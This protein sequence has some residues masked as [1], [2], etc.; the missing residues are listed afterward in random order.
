MIEL[1]VDGQELC[2][3]VLKD[4]VL[5]NPKMERLSRAQDPK[6][7]SQKVD[8]SRYKQLSR[9]MIRR[10]LADFSEE[11]HEGLQADLKKH[12][13]AE[14]MR[15]LKP[16][17]AISNSKKTRKMVKS[18][19]LKMVFCEMMCMSPQMS[20]QVS[21]DM[22][23]CVYMSIDVYAVSAAAAAAGAAAAATAAA[24]AAAAASAAAAAAAAA[25]LY[26]QC[27]TV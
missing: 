10:A 14:L 21:I 16:M 9:M 22:Y 23:T 8:K 5:S 12:T 24:A 6:L 27:L 15:K 26:K 7:A 4:L 20:L 1:E 11:L 2:P 25:A 18:S 17:G 3:D 19:K 13:R